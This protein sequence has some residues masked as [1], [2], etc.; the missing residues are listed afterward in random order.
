MNTRPLASPRCAPPC[1]RST[2]QVVCPDRRIGAAPSD[3]SLP[4]FTPPTSTPLNKQVVL[5]G[6][7]VQADG[8]I[9]WSAPVFLKGRAWGLGLTAGAWAGGHSGRG[10]R[11]VA[12]LMS[13]AGGGRLRVA[14]PRAAAAPPSQDRAGCAP[15]A[16]SLAWHAGQPRAGPSHAACCWP[17]PPRVRAGCMTQR[18]CLAIMNDK[19]GRAA[20]ARADGRGPRCKGEWRHGGRELPGRLALPSRGSP[21]TATTPLTRTHPFGPPT[22]HGGRAEA[23]PQLGAE[24]LVPD[25]HGRLAPAPHERQQQRRALPGAPRA[26]QGC[27]GGAGWPGRAAAGVRCDVAALN[28]TP[29]PTQPPPHAC[30]PLIRASVCEQVLTGANGGMMA[31]TTKYCLLNAASQHPFTRPSALTCRSCRMPTA[32]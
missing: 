1:L 11:Q 31:Q 30:L 20:L 29:P 6:K 4:H 16:C 3:P 26:G 10:A 13:T 24:R 28:K 25:R 8:S 12:R 14:G 32:A 18:M 19:V 27:A 5:I 23:A 17:T 22:G 7:S 21:S 2:P 9:V 15:P